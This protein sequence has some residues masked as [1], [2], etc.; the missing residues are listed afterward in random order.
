MTVVIDSSL[1][2][3]PCLFMQNNQNY[4]KILIK[5]LENIKTSG[6]K[7]K[8]LLHACCGPCLTIPYEEL[9]DYFDITIFFNNSNIY[10]K[11]EHDRRLEE[12]KRFIKENNADIKVIEFSYDNA[13]FN[14]ILEPRKDDKE[15][16]ERCRICFRNRLNEGYKYASENGYEYFGT[17][18]TISRYKNAQ[19]INKIGSE[20]ENIYPNVKWLYADFKKNNG[21]EKSLIVIK[22]YHMYFQEYCGC[23]YSYNS[24]L[25]KHK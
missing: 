8:L 16:H 1:L 13:A 10:P 4:Q 9:K 23:V 11:E 24:Y 12:L 20:L 17:V 3:I 2:E 7:P 21:Y 25:K 5:N 22:D 6:H 14:K 19:D 18:M 15:G